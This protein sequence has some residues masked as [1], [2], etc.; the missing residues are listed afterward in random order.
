MKNKSE[1]I[2]F[3]L[4]INSNERKI[5]SELKNRYSINVSRLIKNYLFDYHRMLDTKTKENNG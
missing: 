5:I 4:H 2:G 1:K 3:Y